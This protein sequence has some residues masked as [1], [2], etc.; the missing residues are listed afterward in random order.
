MAVQVQV[1]G[2]AERGEHPAQVG[3]DVLKD[4]HQRHG[5]FLSGAFEHVIAQGEK[6]QQSHVVGDEHG[7]DKGDIHQGDHRHAQRPEPLHDLSG[8][9]VK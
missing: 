1:L 6:G 5:V 3:G 4:K 8:Q 9:Q 2:V 7:S